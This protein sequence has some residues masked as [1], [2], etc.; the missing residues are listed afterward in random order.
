[1]MFF[2][3]NKWVVGAMLVIL[4]GTPVSFC[5]GEIIFETVK[6]VPCGFI[7]NDQSNEPVVLFEEG[8][9]SEG[10]MERARDVLTGGVIKPL[11]HSMVQICGFQSFSTSYDPHY[12]GVWFEIW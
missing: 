5:L 3:V 10:E 6:G 12:I 4:A 11:D 9:L 7:S 2:S 1:M 8:P